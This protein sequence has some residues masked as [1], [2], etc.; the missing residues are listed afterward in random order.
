MPSKGMSLF[1][2]AL[3]SLRASLRFRERQAAKPMSRT[4]ISRSGF[5]CAPVYTHQK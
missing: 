4:A 2:R 3:T 5:K 1:V